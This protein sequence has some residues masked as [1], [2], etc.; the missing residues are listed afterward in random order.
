MAAD[1]VPELLDKIQKEFNAGMSKSSIVSAVKKSMD[2]GTATYIGANDYAQEVGSILARSFRKH[3]T[4]ES[5]PD[6]R[7]YFNIAD[8]ILGETLKD[9][10]GMVATVA[11]EVQNALNKQAGVGIK[12]IKPKLNQDRI[13]GLVDRIS[14]EVDFEK[15]EW[16]LDEPIVNFSQNV[17]DESIKENFEFQGKSGMSA[18][19]VRIPE[20]GAC[21]WC[22]SVAGEYTYPDVPE[23]V[24]RRHERCRCVIDYTPKKGRTERLSGTGRAWVESNNDE[25]IEQRKKIGVEST[26][27]S[28]TLSKQFADTPAMNEYDYFSPEQEQFRLKS[29]QELSGVSEE[30]SKEMLEALCGTSDEYK[31]VGNNVPQG[32]FSG[33]DTDI[34]NAKSGEYFEK[35]KT[36]D[37]YID[38]SPKYSG[39]I[40]RGLSLDDETIKKFQ[41]GGTFI[42]NGNLSSW[43][44]DKG[45]SQMFAD[46]RSEE[47]GTKRVIIQ[48]SNHPNSTPAS[49][50]SI[51]GSEESEVLV[52][53]MR[54]SEYLIQNV[55]NEDGYVLINLKLKGG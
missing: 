42:E 52:S 28:K 39:D 51:F 22:R 32:W 20:A 38:K 24:W 55:A 41:Q 15:V 19:V 31:G 45:I 11:E 29:I 46:G 21:E 30:E 44:S 18:K 37:S 40:Y 49:H 5:L 33:S 14:N 8:R 13:K 17:V 35:A 54:N 12:A 25:L 26:K 10:H 7:M 50:L 36:I 53:N 34:R 16:L 48:T 27:P 1:I 4:P 2:A 47:L 23:D 6:G 3:I 9:N 43:T